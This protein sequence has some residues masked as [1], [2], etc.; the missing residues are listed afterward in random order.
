MSALN[1]KKSAPPK[2][3][4]SVSDLIVRRSKRKVKAAPMLTED[5]VPAGQYR[6]KIIAVTDAKTDEGK[7]MADVTYRFTNARGKT[8]DARIRYP[9]VGYH[10]EKLYDALIDAGLLEESPLIDAVGIE[11][12][13]EIAYPF[14]GALG[15]IKARSPVAAATPAPV[16]KPKK[17]AALVEEDDADEDDEFD[18][19][20]FLTDDD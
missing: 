13:V 20:D 4:K 16:P 5:I 7:L 10:I 15:K 8:V 2:V 14:E 18:E 11:E 17:R 1:S 12:E 9:A 3:A 6:S 19:D